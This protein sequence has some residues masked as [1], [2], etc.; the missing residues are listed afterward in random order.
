MC[1]GEW[2][3]LFCIEEE[4]NDPPHFFEQLEELFES[5][6]CAVN[7]ATRDGFYQVTVDANYDLDPDSED[8]KELL[9]EKSDACWK[10][11]EGLR[12]KN[13]SDFHSDE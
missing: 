7:K 12:D 3:G 11:I 1:D 5:C 4:E 2:D 10:K 13:Y 6:S 8:Y 9:K